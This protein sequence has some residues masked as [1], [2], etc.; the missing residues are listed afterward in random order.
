[1]PTNITWRYDTSNIRANVAFDVFTAVDP[2]HVNSSGDYELM[3]WYVAVYSG[4][5]SSSRLTVFV[6]A[7]PLR[8]RV[9]HIAVWSA[10]RTSHH[11]GIQVRLVLWIQ[12]LDE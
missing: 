6:Q 1:M 3:V 9:A 10:N 7:R 4:K 11:R 8:W 5:F 2:N 12:R